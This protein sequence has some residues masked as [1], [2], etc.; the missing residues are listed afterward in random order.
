MPP[1][2]IDT[3]MSMSGHYRSDSVLE[4]ASTE[5]YLSHRPSLVIFS[6]HDDL[7]EQREDQTDD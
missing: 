3:S 1:H 7:P 5:R 2:N 4:S 6:L